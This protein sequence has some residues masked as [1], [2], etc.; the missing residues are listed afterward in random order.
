LL[1]SLGEEFDCISLV[2]VDVNTTSP[3]PFNSFEDDMTTCTTDDDH[4]PEPISCLVSDLTP[5]EESLVAR[6]EEIIQFFIDLLQ[7]T[8]CDLST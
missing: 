1:T 4:H 5:E 3:H 2:S 7:V 8:G 6:M